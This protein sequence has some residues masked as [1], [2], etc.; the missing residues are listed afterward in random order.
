MEWVSLKYVNYPVKYSHTDIKRM[1]MSSYQCEYFSGQHF[2]WRHI[3]SLASNTNSKVLIHVTS[4]SEAFF[5]GVNGKTHC[6]QWIKYFS[7]QNCQPS[8]FTR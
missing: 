6:Y 4:V 5:G 1:L 3:D 2:F 8:L 7:L